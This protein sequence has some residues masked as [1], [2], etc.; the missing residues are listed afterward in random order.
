MNGREKQQRIYQDWWIGMEI[1][2]HNCND[3]NKSYPCTN[4]EY[5]SQPS[6]FYGI[7]VLKLAGYGDYIVSPPGNFKRPR[8]TDVT[9]L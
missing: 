5:I 1:I 4:V 6:G 7:C 8:K 3:E 9:I 2:P